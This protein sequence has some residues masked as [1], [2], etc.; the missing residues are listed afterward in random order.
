MHFVFPYVMR[1][2][3]RSLHSVDSLLNNRGAKANGYEGNGDWRHPRVVLS[4]A[5][6]GGLGI[7]GARP[8]KRGAESRSQLNT[9]SHTKTSTW[10]VRMQWL[11]RIKTEVTYVRKTASLQSE[12]E[13]SRLSLT[14]SKR[15]TTTP[16]RILLL[17]YK[18]LISLVL[19]FS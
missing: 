9:F 7:L 19:R 15:V 10:T 18:K 2:I 11:W 3:F 16:S 4:D 6:E 1:M 17:L 13:P 12:I 14:R 5:P 8:S